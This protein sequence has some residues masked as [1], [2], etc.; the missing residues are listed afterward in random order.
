[1]MLFLVC[2]VAATETKPNDTTTVETTAESESST[3][4]SDERIDLECRFNGMDETKSYWKWKGNWQLRNDG[5]HAGKHPG[6]N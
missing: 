2:D 3:P 4:K 1:M 6:K 5:A